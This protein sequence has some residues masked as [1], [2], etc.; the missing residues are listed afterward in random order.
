MISN[1][2]INFL[3][4]LLTAIFSV[5][6]KIDTFPTINGYDIDAALVT[7]VGQFHLVAQNYW[8]LTYMFGGFLFL[9]AYY[10]L[11]ILTRFFFGSRSPG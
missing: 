3:V 2:L 6:P 8:F 11:K 5:F 9:S 4:L 1:L 10:L 7:G